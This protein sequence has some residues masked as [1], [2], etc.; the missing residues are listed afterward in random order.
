MFVASPRPAI[1]ELLAQGICPNEIARRLGLAGTTVAHHIR[2]LESDDRVPEEDVEQPTTTGRSQIP[3]RELVAG[4]LAQGLSRTQIA[5]ELGLT[6]ATVSYHARRLGA[7]VDSRCARRYDW[8]L[9]QEYYDQGHSVRDCRERFGF[10]GR[11]WTDAVRRGAV[12][13]RPAAMPLERLLVAGTYRG[14]HNLKSR[15][16]EA[17]VKTP[18]CERCGLTEWRGRPLPFALHHANGDRYDNRLENLQLLCP[19]C[20]GQ[21]DTRA[22]RIRRSQTPQSLTG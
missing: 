15:L 6:K 21:V 22:R 4:L 13:P 17:G 16:L 3:S 9:V 10:S 20:H 8:R 11:T 14:R 7:S 2:K 19:N 18:R 5:H 12:T 1:R